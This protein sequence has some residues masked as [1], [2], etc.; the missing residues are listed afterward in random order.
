MM[1]CRKCFAA[2]VCVL[3]IGLSTP[4]VSLAQLSTVGREFWFGFMENNRVQGTNPFNGAPDVGIIIITAEENT[5]GVI[6]YQA[7]TITFSLNA[8]QQFIYRIE[9]FDIIHR[10]SGVVESKWVYIT[11]LEMYLCMHLTNV[12]DPLMVP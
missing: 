7:N 5:T 12:Y 3:V 2:F 10:T 8:G 1:D 4:S 6:Q 9:D 11:S